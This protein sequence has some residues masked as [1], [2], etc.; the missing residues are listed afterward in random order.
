MVKCKGV[1]ARNFSDEITIF[2]KGIGA[3][4]CFYFVVPNEIIIKKL[5]ISKGLASLI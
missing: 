5:M 4:Y 2:F 3:L 1:A